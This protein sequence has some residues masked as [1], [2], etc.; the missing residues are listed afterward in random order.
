MHPWRKKKM[1]PLQYPGKKMGRDVSRY[2]FSFR[3]CVSAMLAH[4]VLMWLVPLK[5]V[6]WI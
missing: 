5:V 4:I 1:D 2:M 3:T 6:G